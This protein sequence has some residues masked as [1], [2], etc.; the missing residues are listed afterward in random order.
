MSPRPRTTKG[1]RNTWTTQPRQP[2]LRLGVQVAPPLQPQLRPG[3][4]VTMVAG[5]GVAEALVK[6]GEPHRP[7]SRAKGGV[8]A[9]MP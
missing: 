9:A 8:F 3:V 4:T 6:R 5:V 7:Q 1:R 2:Q